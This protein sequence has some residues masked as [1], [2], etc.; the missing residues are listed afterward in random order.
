MMM[1]CLALAVSSSTL[2]AC[3][4]LRAAAPRRCA[5]RLCTTDRPHHAWLE[6]LGHAEDG[7]H[8]H[9][10]GVAAACYG[11]FSR[12]ASD[13]SF[14]SEVWARRPMLLENV[15]GIAGSYTLAQL[16]HA[17]DHD[18]LDAGRG[19]PDE[20]APGGWKMAPVS[21]PRGPAFEDAKMRCV[22][23][24]TRTHAPVICSR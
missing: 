5:P 22:D 6:S 19:V 2:T 18:F 15:A 4:L 11:L 7:H 24:P 17:V 1:L 10:P 8:V 20:D 23:A 21:Q 16:Q 9:G 14:A 13:E 3:S 12:L